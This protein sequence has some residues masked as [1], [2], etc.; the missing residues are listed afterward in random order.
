MKVPEKAAPA[1]SKAAPVQETSLA[2]AAPKPPLHIPEDFGVSM[3]ATLVSE[4]GNSVISNDGNSVISNDGHSLTLLAADEVRYGAGSVLQAYAGMYETS[5]KG[6]NALLALAKANEED[7]LAGKSVPLLGLPGLGAFT[8]DLKVKADHAELTFWAGDGATRH[9][10]LWLSFTDEKHGQGIFHPI[11]GKH[12]MAFVTH[13]D[14]AKNQGNA[15][16]YFTQD[17]LFGHSRAHIEVESFPAAQGDQPV[18]KVKLGGWMH[19][20]AF[21]AAGAVVGTANVLK[22]GSASAIYGVKAPGA[23]AFAFK[24][25]MMADAPEGR[26]GIYLDKSAGETN[27]DLVT[28]AQRAAVPPDDD[29][30]APD[31][32][33]PESLPPVTPDPTNPEAPIDGTFADPTFRFPI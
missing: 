1:D 19:D 30:S 13:F 7:L 32:P 11:T 33:D 26:H 15:D 17:E 28:A 16:V 12:P 14:L 4:A 6:A 23:T 2:T 8:M 10:F 21:L 5:R 22:D 31:F 9:R 25:G 27:P 29:V 20:A 24:S 18:F 3:P